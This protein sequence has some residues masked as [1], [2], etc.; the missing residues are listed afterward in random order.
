MLNVRI[1]DSKHKQ[2]LYFSQYELYDELFNK[3]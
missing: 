1:T 3:T 2:M